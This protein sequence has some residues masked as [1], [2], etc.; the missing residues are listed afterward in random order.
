MATSGDLVDMRVIM[1]GRGRQPKRTQVQR[2]KETQ[3][4][5]L[6]ASI[7]LLARHGY[8]SFSA[9][10][11][12]AEAGVSR[13]AQEHYFPKKRDLVAATTTYAMNK[14]VEHAQSLARSATRSK[15]PI[16][17]FLKDSEHFFFAPV[18]Q[19]MAEIVI[20]AR[21]DR[22]LARTLH[23]IIQDARNVLNGI[24]LETLMAAGYPRARAQEFIELTHYLLRGLFFVKYWL[25]YNVDRGEV[26]ATWRSLAP[27]ILQ[28]ATAS[29]SIGGPPRRSTRA[30]PK[31]SG[32]RRNSGGKYLERSL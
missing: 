21:S 10:R 20:A 32:I 4:A 26:I 15:D 7:R 31:V 28:H 6:S 8:A 2:R 27:A 17:K 12:A 25:P 30:N 19:A 13:G 22:A 1:R 18:F 16:D 24:W 29:R 9:S 5:I 3:A 14:A 11:V 23:P